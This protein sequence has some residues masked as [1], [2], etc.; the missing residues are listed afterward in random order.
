[1]EHDLTENPAR[2][3][4]TRFELAIGRMIEGWLSAGRVAVSAD[5]VELAREF[6]KQAGCTVEDAPEARLRVV[7]HEG[8]CEEMTREG[9]VMAALRHLATHR[10]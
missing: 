4:R 6:L 2:A 10:P 8:F 1:V 7:S 5:D 9:A 3:V